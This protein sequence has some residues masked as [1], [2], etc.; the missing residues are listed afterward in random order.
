MPTIAAV[1]L[2]GGK[3]SRMGQ[4]KSQL[5]L[6]NRTL[7]AHTKE[8]LLAAGNTEIVISG[9]LGIKDKQTNKG[10]LSGL[11]SCLEELRHYNYL[12]FVPVDMPL[13][14]TDIIKQLLQEID[15]ET[16]HQLFHFNNHRLPLI[17]Q[18]TPEIRLVIEKQL[19][20]DD[21]SLHQLFKHLKTKTL[22][23]NFESECFF[24]ANSPE[25]WQS[26]LDKLKL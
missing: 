21:L 12:F 3:S 18:N 14:S 13:L 8:L 1:I 26:V 17:L 20:S 22:K 15:Q 7:L 6:G 23:H 24:N 19:H 25:Q 16:V 11:F 4:D 2:A 10:P 5:M 9:A